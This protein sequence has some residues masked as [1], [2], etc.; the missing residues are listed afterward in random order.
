MNAKTTEAKP[1][2]SPSDLTRNQ[3]KKLKRLLPPAKPGGRPRSVNLRE[4]LNGIYYIAR[5]GGSWRM[6]PKDLPPWSTCYDYFRKWRNDGTWAKVNDVLRTRVRHR[7]GREKSPSMGIIDS[8]SVKTTEQGGP[9]GK[10]AFKKVNGRK[11]H[12]VIDTLGMV[13]AAVVHS[14]GIQDR[15]GAKLV[16]K[17]MVGRFPRLKKILADGIYNG[18]IAEWAEAVGGWILEL[19]VRPEGQTKFEVLPWRWIVERTFAWLGRY[20]R[21]S[22]DY[23]GSE[24]SSEAWIYVA[25]T[26]LMLR[27]LE[28]A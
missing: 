26:H 22:K 1:K 10:D 25:M 3:W 19:V 27:R 9:R 11:R 14:A 6:M 18:G 17:K 5:G 15:D 4:V 16:L 23:E 24:E 20:R 8:Q 21:L 28:S 12:L 2:R 7:A 13:V